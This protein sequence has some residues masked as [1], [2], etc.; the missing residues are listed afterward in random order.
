MACW[1]ALLKIAEIL[2]QLLTSTIAHIFRDLL[3]AAIQT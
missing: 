1:G 2:W 3:N